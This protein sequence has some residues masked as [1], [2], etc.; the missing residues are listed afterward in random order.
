[1]T[2]DPVLEPAAVFKATVN[3]NVREPVP[4]VP[5][6][7]VIHDTLLE[8]SQKQPEGAVRVTVP[9]PPAAGIERLVASSSNVQPAPAWETVKR[10]PP[11]VRSPV[12]YVP[13]VFGSTL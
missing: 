9:V 2:S 1:M 11:M 7:I 3:V 5:D 4:L 12:R 8:A 10:W 6:V 13:D